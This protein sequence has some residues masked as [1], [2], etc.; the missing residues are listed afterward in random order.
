MQLTKIFRTA[1]LGG[2]WLLF[3]LTTGQAQTTATWIGPA[4]GGEWNTPTSWDTGAPPL[5][6]TTNAFIGAA[7]NVSYNLPMTASSFAAL[8]NNGTLN[9]NTNGFNCSSITLLRAGGGNK[10]FV[11]TGAVVNVTGNLAF[12]SNS[13]VSLTA[14]SSVTVQGSLLVGSGATGGTG[15]GTA[16][17]IGIMTNNGATLNASV[18]TINPANASASSLFVIN[19]GTNN[20]GTTTI[21]RSSPSS[22]PAL[23]TEGLLIYGGL[24]TMTNLNVGG[25]ANSY[26]TMLVAGGTVTNMGNVLIQG[27]GANSRPARLLQQGGLF[28]IPDP[29]IVN[30]DPPAAANISIFSVTGGTNIAGGFQFGDSVPDAGTVDFTNAAPIYVG[31]QGIGWNGAI[32]LNTVLK[33][34]GL[35][36]ATADWTGSAP[37][38][39]NGSGVF[40]FQAADMNGTPHNITLTGALGGPSSIALNITGGGTLTLNAANTYLGNTL[41]N[42][43]TLAL[44]ASGSLTSGTIVVGSGTTFDVSQVSGFTLNA[45]QTL[46]GSG[47]VTG[48]V[49]AASSSTIY[50][51]SNTVTGTLTFTSGLTENG[52]VNNEFNLSSNP[53]G[54]NNDFLN[55]SGGLALSGINTITINGS[56][57]PGGGVYPLIYYGSSLSGD[58]NN[59]TVTR[60]S[61]TLSNSPTAETIYFVAQ[62]SIRGPTNITWLGNAAANNWDTETTTNWLN[63]GTGLPTVFVPNDNALFSNLGAS[64][65]AVNIVGSVDPGSV[66]VNTTSNYV[67]TGNGAIGGI[68]SLTVSNGILTVL[69]TNNY[70][71]QTILDGGVLEVS[72]LTDGGVPGNIGAATSDPGNL[73][74]NDGTL[75]YLG[76]STSIDRGATFNPGGGV[77][78]ITN[79]ATELTVSGTLT[80]SGGLTLVDQGELN[81]TGSCSYAGVTTVSNG[82]LLVNGVGTIGTNSIIFAGGTVSLAAAGSAQG[83]QFY[84]NLINVV[85]NS[86]LIVNGGNG[87]NILGSVSGV[88]GLSGSS[89]LNISIP[90]SAGYCTFNASIAA[91]SGTIELGSSVGIFRFNSGGS[92]YC[93]GSTNVTFDLGSGSVT[94][95]NRNGSTYGTTNYYLGAL[96]GGSSTILKGALNTG[97]PN[98][99]QIGDN[100]QSS[101][102]QGLIQN[103]TAAGAVVSIIKTGTGT[104]T[105]TGGNTYSGTTTISN[106]VLALGNVGNGDGSIGSSATINITAGTFLDVSGRSDG[107]LQLGGSQSLLGRGT[108]LGSL[109]ASGA[110]QPGDEPG[111]NTGTLTVTNSINLNGTAWMKLNRTNSPNSD[112]LVS[113]LSSITYSGTL[114]VTN[115]GRQLH[116]G[117]TFT[118]F[119]GS[120]LNGSSFASITLPNYYTWDTSQLGVNGSV[121]VTAVLPPSITKVDYSSLA[122]GT[123]VF[124]ANNGLADGN[125]AILMSTNVAAPLSQW[126]SIATGNFDGSGNLSGF[127]VTVN[128]AL[129]VQFFTLQAF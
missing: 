96:A 67:F 102:F 109:N 2:A 12:T 51:G 55:A 29:D 76:D 43:G 94:M 64:N 66:T 91:F 56:L 30:P 46:S 61:G 115:I 84:A 90:N 97:T 59:F 48:A 122:S 34:G 126:T 128:P 68:G 79:G 38:N 103:G 35:F 121:S 92:D 127:S 31:S 58:T 21:K 101:T 10:L 95:A 88:G 22:Q 78:D 60:A 70:T 52:G 44:G 47:T 112:R 99:Y 4:S 33:G 37:L 106:G 3:A 111:G 110:V 71:G 25:N 107:T 36:G 116:A 75:M 123:L 32:T 1:S 80:G 23:G 5:D 24:V 87:N 86:T 8:T 57:A 72:D 83:Q 63:N 15:T 11:N 117:D 69:T 105:L 6:S 120:G 65:L 89:N 26:L 45:N 85:S 18:T 93:T 62:S 118:L 113:S 53:S 19:G 50:P 108:I 82:T 9:V 39:M 129:P 73:V 104:L 40:T 54:P 28:V 16:G 74:F 124:N 17:C 41:I 20:L 98:N 81:L 100:N 49:V 125:F 27:T 119:S 114:V 7:T 14:G 42:A 13:V 77:F